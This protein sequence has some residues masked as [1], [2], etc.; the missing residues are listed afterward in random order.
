MNKG[1]KSARTKY[2]IGAIVIGGAFLYL[3][4][5]SF[6]A[7]FQ[8]ALTSGEFFADEGKYAGRSVKIAGTVEKGSITAKGTDYYFSLSGAGAPPLKV[9]YTG[10][11]PNTFREGA[12]VVV[13]GVF[14][15]E[16][17]L[18]ET[19]EMITKCASKYEER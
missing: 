10:I 6:S 17:D 7:S 11:A 5:T 16:S 4:W 14:N 19:R 3:I 1:A 18:F 9:H 15:R 13:S 8:F 12:D 2:V